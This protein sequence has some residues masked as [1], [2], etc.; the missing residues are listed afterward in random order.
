MSFLSPLCPSFPTSSLSASLVNSSC[1]GLNSYFSPSA[2]QT[3]HISCLGCRPD[4]IIISLLPFS[5]PYHS[6]PINWPEC[7]LNINYILSLLFIKPSQSCPITFRV[8]S[9]CLLLGS[10]VLP[11]DVAPT[12]IS[13]S[14]QTS[15]P[16]FLRSNFSVLLSDLCTITAYSTLGSLQKLC[17]L[18]GMLLPRLPATPLTPPPTKIVT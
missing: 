3:Q 8:K 16:Y 18:S 7:F 2:S 15:P 17:L 10:K 4:L 1:I 6:F 14:S 5:L 9:K 13:D 11:H 12:H